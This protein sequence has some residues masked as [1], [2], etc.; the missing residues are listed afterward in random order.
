MAWASVVPGN[1]RSGLVARLLGGLTHDSRQ[2]ASPTTDSG[3]AG[4]QPANI[5][6][7]HRRSNA[8]HAKLLLR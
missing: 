4:N 3:H 1:P 8:A 5:R 7:I 2:K 6:L